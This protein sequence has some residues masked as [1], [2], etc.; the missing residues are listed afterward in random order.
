MEHCG[1]FAF[2]ALD[3]ASALDGT[4]DKPI[5]IFGA[6]VLTYKGDLISCIQRRGWIEQSEKF[7]LT[8]L[9]FLG[10][11]DS[12]YNPHVRYHNAAHA[13]DVMATMDVFMRAPFVL[14][15]STSL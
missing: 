11:L 14:Q 12:S 2:D 10:Q 6:H 5:S 9:A 4:S 3:L 7:S 8:F 13:V 15:R 1:G